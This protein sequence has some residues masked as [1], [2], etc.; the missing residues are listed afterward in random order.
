M[1]TGHGKDMPPGQHML[2]QPLRPRDVALAPAEDRLHQRI[3]ASY[4]IADH[5]EIRRDGDLIFAESLAKLDA[6]RLELI[7]HRRVDIG[8]AAG[9]AIARGA[10]D[11]RDAAHERAANTEDVEVLRHRGERRFY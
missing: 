11:R 9:H 6:E 7:A 2:R 5:P 10:R 4:H 8:I 1:R 3:A